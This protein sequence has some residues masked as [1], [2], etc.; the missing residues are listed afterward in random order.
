M[1]ELIKTN[2][3]VVATIKH[4]ETEIRKIRDVLTAWNAN[5]PGDQAAI[6]LQTFYNSIP[7]V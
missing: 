4:D 2:A 7:G 5:S 6:D 1:A 3:R